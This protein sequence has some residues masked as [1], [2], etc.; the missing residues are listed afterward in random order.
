MVNYQTGRGFLSRDLEVDQD[1]K[2]LE[3][4]NVSGIEFEIEA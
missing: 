4:T 2:A 3:Y 1:P